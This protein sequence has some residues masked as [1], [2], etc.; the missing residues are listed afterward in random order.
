M[1]YKNIFVRVIFS[2]LNTH[3]QSSI[4]VTVIV[5]TILKYSHQLKNITEK[6]Q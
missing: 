3:T 2:F 4:E 1:N 6:C 5:P